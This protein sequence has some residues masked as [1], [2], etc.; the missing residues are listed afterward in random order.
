MTYYRERYGLTPDN[1]PAAERH[2]LGVVTLPV[3]AALSNEDLAY[4][5]DTI[6]TLLGDSPP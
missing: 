2:W 3:Y 5:C 4:V 1:Y 6:K